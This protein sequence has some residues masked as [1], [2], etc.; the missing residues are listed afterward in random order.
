MVGFPGETEADFEDMR[1][2]LD[3]SPLTYF[4]VFSY[5]PRQGTP[6]EARPRVPDG[7]VTE[8]AKALRRLSAMKDFRFRRRFQGREL[9]AVVIDKSE[10]G[11]VVLTGNF[12]KVSVP[13]CPAPEREIV[14]VA[15]RRVLP[16]RTEGEIVA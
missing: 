12:I 9:E 5:S 15:L 1:D 2:F 16:R 6:A 13:G 7:V 4:H 14:R 10:R 3:R 11:T 8:R